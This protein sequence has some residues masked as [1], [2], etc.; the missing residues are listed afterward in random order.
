MA[1]DEWAGLL[2]DSLRKMFIEKYLTDTDAWYLAKPDQLIVPQALE[3]TATEILRL[4]SPP[5]PPAPEPRLPLESIID[6]QCRK[7]K[8]VSYD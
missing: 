6:E 4:Q 1:T 2:D 7:L 8:E 3:K 5:D